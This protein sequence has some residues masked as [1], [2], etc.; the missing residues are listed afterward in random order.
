MGK[1]V[2][3]KSDATAESDEKPEVQSVREENRRLFELVDRLIATQESEQRHRKVIESELQQ[4]KFALV[5]KSTGAE[6]DATEPLDTS[7]FG[8]N[9]EK[10]LESLGAGLEEKFLARLDEVEERLTASA[11]EP[12]AA[13]S[14]DPKATEDLV[15][16]IWKMI[17]PLGGELERLSSTMQDI[18]QQVDQSKTESPLANT[19]IAQE[20]KALSEEVQQLRGEG[21]PVQQDGGEKNEILEGLSDRLDEIGQSLKDLTARQNDAQ[22]QAETLLRD[23]VENHMERLSREW[24]GQIAGFQRSVDDLLLD[25]APRTKPITQDL[26]DIDSE[27]TASGNGQS[28]DPQDATPNVVTGDFGSSQK[29]EA[30]P[31]SD[32]KEPEVGSGGMSPDLERE[33]RAMDVGDE[34]SV[35]SIDVK[36]ALSEGLGADVSSI[37]AEG[38]NTEDALLTKPADWRIGKETEEEAILLSHPIVA[39]GEEKDTEAEPEVESVKQV[40]LAN[41]TA[42]ATSGRREIDL[43]AFKD[44]RLSNEPGEGENSS[45]KLPT[46]ARAPSYENAP[47]EASLTRFVRLIRAR[48]RSSPS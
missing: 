27:V 43:R 41:E 21:S 42:A 6:N 24:A 26:S 14:E 17:A 19:A 29:M 12:D 31:A 8:E 4:M 9:F 36:D 2:T 45:A 1:D 34:A 32:S 28:S 46:G 5:K 7:K 44:L 35:K 22:V 38:P 23:L 18:G 33:M 20:L 39:D 40:E 11:P 48:K 30:S 25:R 3:D 13:G 10:L 16:T 37:V 47:A 15:N